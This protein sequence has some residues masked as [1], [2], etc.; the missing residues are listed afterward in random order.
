ML[1]R[2]GRRSGSQARRERLRRAS[3]THSQAMPRVQVAH[4][5]LTPAVRDMPRLSGHWNKAFNK[6]AEH[7]RSDSVR[8]A[9]QARGQ[10]ARP[11]RRPE[12][13]HAQSDRQLRRRRERQRSLSA[14]HRGR[15]RPEPLHAVGQPRVPDLQPQRHSC[16]QHHAGLPALHRPVGVR[17]PAAGTAATRSSSTT[18]SRTAGSLL[19]WRIRPIRTGRSTSASRT[20]R[21]ATR[22]ARGAH[23]S[24]SR[25]RPT[26]TTIRSS[27]SGRPSTPT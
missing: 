26:S 14:R 25:T 18:S 13:R 15:H 23:T 17:K 24:T 22:R 5:V 19:S 4:G 12:E 20:P 9:R 8:H 6:V 16:E 27:A 2:P 21:R 1:R 7:S 3:I 10:R 11:A